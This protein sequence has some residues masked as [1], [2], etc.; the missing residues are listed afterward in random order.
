MNLLGLS[1]CY[2]NKKYYCTTQISVVFVF[3]LNQSLS[4]SGINYFY[5]TEPSEW[6][7]VG[8]LEWK[9]KTSHIIYLYLLSGTL[10]ATTKITY[11]RKGARIILKLAGMR[12]SHILTR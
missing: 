10:L 12:F 7:R 5:E 9:T 4:I 8:F 6:S 2:H 11:A 3:L 1:N